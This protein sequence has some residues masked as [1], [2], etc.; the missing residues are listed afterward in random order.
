[1]GKAKDGGV[2]WKADDA[3]KYTEGQGGEQQDQENCFVVWRVISRQEDG[4][5]FSRVLYGGVGIVIN[6]I[7]IYYY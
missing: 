4:L 2:Q 1:M 7:I 6:Y 5:T 3:E